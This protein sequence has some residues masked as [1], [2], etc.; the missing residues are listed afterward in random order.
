MPG[1]YASA[2]EQLMRIARLPESV[3]VAQRPVFRTCLACWAGASTTTSTTG[4]ACSCT[5][6]PS[7]ATKQDMEKMMGLDS[8]VDFVSDESV[9]LGQRLARLPWLISILVRMAL[10]FAN[11][12]HEVT[13][14]IAQFDIAYRRIDR[15]RFAT[16]TFPS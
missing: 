6:R 7:A 1:N 14:F 3:I 9:S 13:R 4:I 2:Y 8:P 16:A 10:R 12:E 11:I 5:C 15:R